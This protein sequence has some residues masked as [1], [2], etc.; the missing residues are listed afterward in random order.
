MSDESQIN[1]LIMRVHEAA[2]SNENQ[3]RRLR[4]GPRFSFNWEIPIV[5]VELFRIDISRYFSEPRYYFEKEL[6]F[7]L[8]RWETFSDD[9]QPLEPVVNAWLGWYPEYTY[10][11]I[12][13]RWASNGAPVLQD[14][15][16]MRKSADMSLLDP[17]DFKTSGWMPRVLRWYQDLKEIAAGR[18]RVAFEMPWWRGGLD[19][20]IQLRGFEQFVMDCYER[21]AFV[22]ELIAFLVEQRCRW[23]AA[24]TEHFGQSEGNRAGIAPT[25]IGDDWINIPFIT[26]EIFRDFVLPYYK[27]IETFH[28]GITGVHS[29][30]NQV[31][32]QKF[33]LELKTLPCF[34][35]SPWSVLDASLEN[36]PED[37][38][39]QISLSSTDVLMMDQIQIK[40][41]LQEIADKCRGRSFN[42][43]TSG[44]STIINDHDAFI[45][46]VR[47]WTRVA[48]GVKDNI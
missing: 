10:V 39:L 44:L 24:F 6:E 2:A 34:E 32:V 13:V 25:F 19:L 22:H 12:D 31:P 42:V 7:L 40:H 4:R 27:K 14:D 23:H 33:L 8:W 21:P 26:P 35:V 45:E 18:I 15:H 30:G 11:G 46:Q 17:V 20:A 28:G 3:Q 1:D 38:I 48:R 16:P 29:C 47:L 41:Q 9:Q 37:K 43:G 36:I 5:W